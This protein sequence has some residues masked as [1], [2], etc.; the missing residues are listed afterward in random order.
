M[1]DMSTQLRILDRGIRSEIPKIKGSRFIATVQPIEAEGELPAVLHPLRVEFPQANHHCWAWRLGR[2]RDHV[3]WSDDGEPSGSAGR[4]IL[5]QIEGHHLTNVVVVVT[6]IFGGTRLGVGGL[7]RAYSGAAGHALDQCPSREWIQ[8][9]RLRV[10]CAYEFEGVVK[11]VLQQS[12][13]EPA[14]S[15]Y[16]EQVH[17][18]V[19]VPD[20]EADAVIDALRERT[21]ARARI[22][23]L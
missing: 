8:Q 5:Q 6:R 17:L 19:L 1:P 15:R 11:A 23:A 18:E 22:V 3:R 16:D 4:P 14:A 20:A 9:R 7:V 2:S 10:S 21:A 12:G 13:L